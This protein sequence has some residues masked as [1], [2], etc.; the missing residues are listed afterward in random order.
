[1]VHGN[2]CR[3][4]DCE[5]VAPVCRECG[6]SVNT[7]MGE[8][9]YDADWT[10]AAC[11]TLPECEHCGRHTVDAVDRT[12]AVGAFW[13]MPAEIVCDECWT[14]HCERQQAAEGV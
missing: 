12:S 6:D 10:C 9:H 2:L 3:C 8:Q 4:A 11:L 5:Y 14:A 1:M 13:G 7:R